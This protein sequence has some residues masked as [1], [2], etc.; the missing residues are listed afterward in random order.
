MPKDLSQYAKG[1]CQKDK[2]TVSVCNNPLSMCQEHGTNLQQS[3]VYAPLHS[4][5]LV[6][7]YC[8]STLLFQDTICI[9]S[10]L[11]FIRH[12]NKYSTVQC[13]NS[14]FLVHH[15]ITLHSD[16]PT[17]SIQITNSYICK[18]VKSLFAICQWYC[19]NVSIVYSKYASSNILICQ[20]SP[21]GMA[22]VFSIRPT[23]SQN[24]NSPF[25]LYQLPIAACQ[26]LCFRG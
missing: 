10:L 1:L 19:S 25:C 13:A 20:Q 7:V 14:L 17:V 9:Q 2:N 22:T 23:I 8:M 18:I 11:V 26:P 24:A 6:C 5:A 3:S 12:A 15:Y 4:T 21:L 16:T